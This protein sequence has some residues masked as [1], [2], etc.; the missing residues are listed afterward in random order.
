MAAR[1]LGFKMA[2]VKQDNKT[3]FAWVDLM[4]NGASALCQA[5]DT[6]TEALINA[7]KFITDYISC[8]KPPSASP[9]SN[10]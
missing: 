7:C 6:E 10:S 2:R 9:S 4:N 3:S 5:A 1:R 8:P